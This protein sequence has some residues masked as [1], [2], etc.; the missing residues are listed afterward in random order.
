MQP[1][2]TS[3]EGYVGTSEELD[4]RRRINRRGTAQQRDHPVPRLR[5]LKRAW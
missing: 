4:F 1:R 2:D 3:E 5:S